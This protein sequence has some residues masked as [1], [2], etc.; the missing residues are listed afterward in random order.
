MIILGKVFLLS[1][2]IVMI[3]ILT[4]FSIFYNDLKNEERTLDLVDINSLGIT[5][6]TLLSLSI[7]F[8][9]YYIYQSFS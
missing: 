6:F 8:T 9:S 4:V 7:L 2:M 1:Q 5:S 3:Y